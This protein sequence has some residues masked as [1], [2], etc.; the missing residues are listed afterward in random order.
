M[1]NEQSQTPVVYKAI[2]GVQM[3]LHT[4]RKDMHYYYM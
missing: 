3:N 2:D 1:W 4:T